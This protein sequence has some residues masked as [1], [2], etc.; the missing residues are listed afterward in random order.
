MAKYWGNRTK[1]PVRPKRRYE[2]NPMMNFQYKGKIFYA[3]AKEA[4]RWSRGSIPLI[5][6]LGTRREWLTSRPDCFIPGKKTPV[7][8]E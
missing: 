1:C 2:V 3:H 5:L 4:Y 6:N 8:I 7:S